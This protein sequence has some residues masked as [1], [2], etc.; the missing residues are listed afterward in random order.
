V[1]KARSS[2][3]SRTSEELDLNARMLSTRPLCNGKM[4]SW[5]A[6][7]VPILRP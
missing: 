4:C 6:F 3:E 7:S 5:A 2:F 1:L